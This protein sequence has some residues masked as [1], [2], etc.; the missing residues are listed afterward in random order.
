[1]TALAKSWPLTVQLN[2]GAIRE[3]AEP[4][5]WRIG[6]HVIE[7][8]TYRELWLLGADDVGQLDRLPPAMT[9]RDVARLR[10]V[11]IATADELAASIESTVAMVRPLMG[12]G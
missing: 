2:H 4:R 11:T 6:R 12:R 7:E 5:R 9:D 10:I 8:T 1:M 3:L